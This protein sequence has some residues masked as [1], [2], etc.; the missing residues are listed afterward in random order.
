MI[1]FPRCDE[2]EVPGLR[3]RLRCV[4]LREG[5][6]GRANGW[7]FKPPAVVQ[8]PPWK[9]RPPKLNG[10]DLCHDLTMRGRLAAPV[11]GM[12]RICVFLC[13]FRAPQRTRERAT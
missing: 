3:P 4:A 7:R 2:D 10:D 6:D 11:F 13:R 1:L 8:Q 5:H 12:F 9:S